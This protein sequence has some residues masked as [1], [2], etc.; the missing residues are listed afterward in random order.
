MVT[1]LTRSMSAMKS[2]SSIEALRHT[3]QDA[4]FFCQQDM[5]FHN[6]F[7]RVRPHAK[8]IAKLLLI[9]EFSQIL[10]SSCNM[11]QTQ[12]LLSLF[13]LKKNLHHLHITS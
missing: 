3:F 10:R 13:M 11:F 5:W 12:S 8:V 2:S 7:H 6:A 4:V 1:T 9:I